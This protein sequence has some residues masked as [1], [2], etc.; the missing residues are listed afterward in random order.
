M[1]VSWLADAMLLLSLA[2]TPRGATVTTTLN[3]LEAPTALSAVAAKVYLGVVDTY[4]TTCEKHEMTCRPSAFVVV[5]TPENW[6]RQ[7]HSLYSHS[8][9]E[10]RYD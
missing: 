10:C 9:S 4:D 6:E 3:E 7:P 5:E 2:I 8:Q 1:S